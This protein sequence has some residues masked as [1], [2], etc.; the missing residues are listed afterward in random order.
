[1]GRWTTG[2]VPH[3]HPAGV[4]PGR[5]G[6]SPILGRRSSRPDQ[7]PTGRPALLGQFRADQCPPR[8]ASQRLAGRPAL[9]GRWIGPGAHQRPAGTSVLGGF[10]PDQRST[11]RPAL[12]GRW[13]GAGADERSA[14]RPTLLG[15]RTGA[16][17]RIPGRPAVLVRP[18]ADRPAAAARGPS[19]ADRT[20]SGAARRAPGTGR[21]G[22]GG[23][24]TL[25]DRPVSGHSGERA[26][27]RSGRLVRGTPPRGPGRAP[28]LAGQSVGEPAPG[29][30]RGG[31]V[32]PG[33]ARNPI[34][35]AVPAPAGDPRAVPRGSGGHR[36]VTRRY[37]TDPDRFRPGPR[38]ERVRAQ[39]P[40]LSRARPDERP[41][42]R[43][44]PI[45]ARSRVA[46]RPGGRRSAAGPD[47]GGAAAARPCGTGRA[48][49]AGAASR[50]A[51][52]R[53]P[54]TRPHR[55]PPTP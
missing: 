39:R 13:T 54:G 1:M 36:P 38:D 49:R 2:D 29:Q 12:L 45:R 53:N 6:G 47:V 20:T 40:A 22:A 18:A 34:G 52:R 55:H 21:A 28:V 31:A 3:R 48:R 11:G 17:Q 51:T 23:G 30:R 43:G 5:A 4:V 46:G 7:R 24:A 15:R 26:A 19:G 9:P 37:R 10:G 44:S 50:G 32:R 27:D 16:H 14:G 35:R 8:R 41:S 33:P 42:L 25:L